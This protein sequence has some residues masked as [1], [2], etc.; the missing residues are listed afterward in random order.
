MRCSVAGAVDPKPPKDATDWKQRRKF[1]R[2]KLESHLTVALA[3][4][5]SVMGWCRNV[6]TGGLEA[7]LN[8]SLE[9]GQQVMLKM[10]LPNGMLES[11]ATVCW[12]QG[13]NYGFQFL[14]LSVEQRIRLE[15]LCETLEPEV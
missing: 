5:K 12:S 10:K 13:M 11:R 9:M 6:S 15:S 4:G 14:T 8:T 7:I 3:D 2:F 1:G